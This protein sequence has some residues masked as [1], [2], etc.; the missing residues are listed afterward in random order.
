[1]NTKNKV[2]QVINR[3]NSVYASWDRSTT[4]ETMRKDWD[5]LYK[6]KQ[7]AARIQDVE[8]AGVPCRTLTPSVIRSEAVILYIHGGGF[9]LGSV[10]SHLKLMSDIAN[11]VSCQ[12]VGINY[13]LMPEAIYPSQLDHC[14]NVYC[15]LVKQ[16]S[17]QNIVVMGDSAGGGLAASL[18][19]KVKQTDSGIA[20]PGACVLLSAWLDMTLSGESYVTRE[21]SD[22]VHKTKMLK[23]LAKEYAGDTTDLADPLLSPTFGDLHDLPPTLLQVGDCEIGLDDSVDYASKANAAGSLAELS[24]WPDMIHV[25]QMFSDELPLA[26][27]AIAEIGLF[28]NRHIN[29]ST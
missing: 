29:A 2:D 28:V 20:L 1:M 12:L 26:K 25:F 17:A 5:N 6:S 19:Q 23:V 18:L 15:E 4:I 8:L 3:I 22:P 10:D 9:R 14:F 7:I 21:Q 13:P 11:E 27:K 24:I 16:H